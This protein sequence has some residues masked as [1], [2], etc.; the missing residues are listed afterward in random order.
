MK[1]TLFQNVACPLTFVGGHVYEKTYQFS[2]PSLLP[3]YSQTRTKTNSVKRHAEIPSNGMMK[4]KKYAYKRED[5]VYVV[6][7]CALK[8]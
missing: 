6:P 4:M 3:Y 7:V 5:G 1:K 8:D 2:A